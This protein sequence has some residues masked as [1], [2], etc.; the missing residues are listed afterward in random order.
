M[1]IK[2]YIFTTVSNVSDMLFPFPFYALMIFL[3]FHCVTRVGWTAAESG[4]ICHK[5]GAVWQVI[6]TQ[7]VE[8]SGFFRTNS[9]D[10]FVTQNP[11]DIL[12]WT[13]ITIT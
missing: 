5:M 4:L 11:L 6:Y 12:L 9:T 7:R 3:F 8:W 2:K 1:N 13:V 10:I